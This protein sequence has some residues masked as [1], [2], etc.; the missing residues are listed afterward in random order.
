MIIPYSN[1][2]ATVQSPDYFTHTLNTLI[3]LLSIMQLIR[4]QES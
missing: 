4:L 3:T 2:N 1:L